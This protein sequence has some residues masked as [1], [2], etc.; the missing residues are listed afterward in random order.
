MKAVSRSVTKTDHA[1]KISGKAAYVA[2]CGADG[3]LVGKLLRSSKA[4]AKIRNI[5]IPE[6]PDGYYIIDKNDVPGEN[7][8]HIVKD[9]TPVFADREV[10]F[11]GDPILMTAGP[12]EKTVIRIRDSID[13]EYEE[14]T[15]V[16]DVGESDTVF[17]EYN[18]GKGDVEKAFSEA[19]TVLE[20]TFRTGY[21]EQAYLETQGMMAEPGQ[22]GDILV[23]GSLQCP[24]YIHGALTRV[25]GRDNVRVVTDCTGGGFGGKEDFPSILGCQVAVAANKT[26]RPVRV[27]FDRRED[28]EFTGKRHPSLCTY[29]A[30]VKNGKVTAL[31]AD[32]I[33]N[34]GAYTTLSAVVLQR[35]IIAATGVYDVEN[36]RV[37]GRA[38]KTNTVPC[39]AF[40]GFGAPQVF[41]AVEMIMD[42]LAIVT[43]EDP[44]EFK[45][46]NT[47]KQGSSTSTGGIYHFP[48]PIPEMVEK[49]DKASGFRKKREEYNKPQTGRYRRGIGMSAVFHGMG[50]TGSGEKDF[51][52]AVVKLRKYPD[53]RVEILA[54]NSDMG[55]GVKTTFSKIVA[56]ELGIEPAEVIF[57]NP[58]TG[59]V[60]DSGPTVAS[61]SIM[62]VGEM[63]R[64]AAVRLREESTGGKEIEIE[65]RYKEP[66]FVIPFDIDKF[67]GDAYPTYAWAVNAVEVEIDVLTGQT[68]VTG[69]W[70]TYDVGTPIDLNIVKGQMEGGL[71]QGIGYASTEQMACDAN[72]RIRNNG[73][74]DYIIP[75]A[76]DV[77]DLSVD[78]HITEYPN[79][80]FGAK[81]AGE[82][83][84]VGV[85]SA[86]VQAAEQ[87]LGVKI[88]KL[89]FSA[90][91]V[92]RAG[93][94]AEK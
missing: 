7:R 46:R 21:Q 67:E 9:D 60:P 29:K 41:F 82:L 42:H 49:T 32:I 85:P 76:A 50:F 13:V 93:K 64:R 72:G 24:Y 5:T 10:E 14:L 28:M 47:A 81:G 16:F 70:G 73:F 80:P 75:C 39:G 3:M 68:K 62:V 87:A 52:K 38:V 83:P 12:D 90:E 91:D 77:P 84:L 65:E 71:L 54:S 36:L 78:L 33:Y 30:A 45:L 88:Y 48:V 55:Q 69:A 89:P 58:D 25:M 11:V 19:D 66:E 26:Q 1:P 63:L 20:E 8:V 43:G 40:R 59:R 2:D 6:L 44:L 86:F 74:A 37:R 51:I 92:L 31:D 18:Y 34:A 61:R 57:E 23:H 79:G 56:H 22:N 27:V 35:G 4:R 94:E 17:F 15:P 53:G